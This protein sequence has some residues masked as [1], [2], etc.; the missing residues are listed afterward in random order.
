MKRKDLSEQEDKGLD[1]KEALLRASALCSRQEQCAGHIREK[2]RG[3]NVEDDDVKRIIK[4]LQ[5][6]NFLNDNR[7]ATFFVKDKFRFNRWGKIKISHILRQKGIGGETIREALEQINQEDYFQTCLDLIQSK[8]ATLKEKN[9]FTRKAK[10]FRFASN[11]G[12]ESDLIHRILNLE[13]N[14]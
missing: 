11:R 13:D 3:W 2:L 4:K 7:Y 12:F 8:S 14:D 5:E 1:Y 9:Q 10:L 6:E